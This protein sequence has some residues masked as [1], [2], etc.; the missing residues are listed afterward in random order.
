MWLHPKCVFDKDHVA[1]TLTKEQWEKCRCV[2]NGKSIADVHAQIP[3]NCNKKQIFC[4]KKIFTTPIKENDP[5]RYIEDSNNNDS[6][7]DF[8]I[9]NTFKSSRNSMYTFYS[10]ASIIKHSNKSPE[11]YFQSV[12]DE[13]L[14]GPKKFNQNSH[15]RINEDRSCAFE[16]IKKIF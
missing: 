8:Q 16:S 3:F 6:N 15:I 2:C 4:H 10:K 13:F 14:G 5:N 12:S 9:L 1:L 7:D 11:N